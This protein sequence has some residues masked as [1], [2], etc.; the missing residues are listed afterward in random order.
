MYKNILIERYELYPTVAK[1]FDVNTD[2]DIIDKYKQDISPY[3]FN[4]VKMTD[5]T[6]GLEKAFQSRL[7]IVLSSV[8][9]RSM[10]LKDASVRALNDNNIPGFY[11]LVKS[12]L[13]V[14]ALLGYIVYLIYNSNDYEKEILPSLV[15]LSLGMKSAGSFSVGSTEAF[16]ILTMF[17]KLDKVIK[18]IGADG[19]TTQEKK[20][21]FD[22]ENIMTSFYSDVCNY[23]HINWAAHLSVGILDKDGIWNA[24]SSL[25]GYKTELY[26]FYMPPF[27]V[28]IETIKMLCSMIM[29]NGKVNN[30]KLLE[31]RLMFS[32][33]QTL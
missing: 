27:V 15:K 31:N 11:S 9:L 18:G 20:Q 19:K 29:R 25:V 5:Y 14:P 1:D 4:A 7:Q 8:L 2:F 3:V 22:G 30:F 10:L 32:N 28:G 6:E 23:G 26:G 24:K 13:E 17:K 16:N 33:N 12:F 21:I